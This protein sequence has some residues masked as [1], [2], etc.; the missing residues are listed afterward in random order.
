MQE[1][2]RTLRRW[3]Q[4]HGPD[5]WHQVAM[6]WNWDAGIDILAWI[7]AQPD[8]DRATAQHLIIGCGPHY[9]LRFPNRGAV[10]VDAPYSIEPFDLLFRTAER[11]NSGF[12]ARSQ[13][14]TSEPDDLRREEREYRLAEAE[15]GSPAWRLDA[16]VF[17]PLQGR[18]LSYRY[19]E[20][21]PPDVAA[22][23]KA[24]GVAF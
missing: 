18:E 23:L 24:R 15:Y 9:Y 8:C 21:W 17:R 13:I 11:W 22:E 12:Y 1:H 2:E 19:A 7:A 10:L 5:D 14:A 16:G 6:D 4:A 3:L 20:G